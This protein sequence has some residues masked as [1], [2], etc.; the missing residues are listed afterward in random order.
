MEHQNMQDFVSGQFRDQSLKSSG[1]RMLQTVYNGVTF[2]DFLKHRRTYSGDWK[3]V[4]VV[5]KVIS[6]SSL[7]D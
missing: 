7:T 3:I 5:A 1:Q 6:M 2:E 4:S